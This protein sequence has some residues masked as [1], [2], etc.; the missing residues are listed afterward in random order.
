MAIFGAKPGEQLISMD[1]SQSLYFA[2]SVATFTYSENS[3]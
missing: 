3:S 1:T 2:G